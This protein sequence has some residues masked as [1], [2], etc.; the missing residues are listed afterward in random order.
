MTPNQ[1]ITQL[2]ACQK[3]LAA[4]V[5]DAQ[6]LEK[7]E[8]EFATHHYQFRRDEISNAISRVLHDIEI[9]RSRLHIIIKKLHEINSS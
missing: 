8:L 1:L 2:E 7:F 6:E 4:L 3:Q 9:I 5:Q